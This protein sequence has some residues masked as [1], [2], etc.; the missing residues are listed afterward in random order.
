MKA[1]LKRLLLAGGLA[2]AGV[3]AARAADEATAAKPDVK[4]KAEADKA[5]A[6]DVKNLKDQLAKQADAVLA[7]RQ[8]M[9]DQLKTAT[10]E[11]RKAILEKMK[12]Q[13]QDFVEAQHSLYLQLRDEMRQTRQGQRRGGG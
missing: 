6:A 4:A 10:E 3:V 9:I 12:A 5:K 2:I 11:Q 13:Q 7:A 8:K 1:S